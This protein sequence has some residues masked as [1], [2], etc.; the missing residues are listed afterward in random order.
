ML[1]F[2][3]IF[4]Q[5]ILYVVLSPLIL[6]TLAVY[7][8]YCVLAFIYIAIRSIIVFFMGGTP[9]G[10]LPEDVEAK[11]ILMERQEQS[12][13]DSTQALA[14]ALMQSQMQIAQ[15]MYGQPSVAPQPTPTEQPNEPEVPYEEE[16]DDGENE[17]EE[18]DD[19]GRSY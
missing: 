19:D 2:L 4:L 16:Y 8:A 18:L 12:R 14:N 17:I 3:K 11:R 9:L 5:G 15:S 13:Q 7:A 6:L 10:D 1:G